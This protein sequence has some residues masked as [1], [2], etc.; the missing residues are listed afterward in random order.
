VPPTAPPEKPEDERGA[1][2]D[3]KGETQ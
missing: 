1:G 2:D 3:E